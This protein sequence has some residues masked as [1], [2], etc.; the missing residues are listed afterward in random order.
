MRQG[1]S[2]EDVATEPYTARGDDA[3][4]RIR[5]LGKTF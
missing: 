5:F 4:G 1:R 2:S 3:S